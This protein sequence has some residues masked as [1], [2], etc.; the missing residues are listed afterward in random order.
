VSRVLA[1]VLEASVTRT[2]RP[3]AAPRFARTIPVTRPV[4]EIASHGGK[5]TPRLHR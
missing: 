1:D 3:T 5:V 2:V 4:D